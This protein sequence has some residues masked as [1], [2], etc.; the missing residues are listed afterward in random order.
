[1]VQQE[2]QLYEDIIDMEQDL[3]DQLPSR[4][5]DKV[6]FIQV[7]TVEKCICWVKVGLAAP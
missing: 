5:M 4:V 6:S 7:K 1:M 3:D 2:R